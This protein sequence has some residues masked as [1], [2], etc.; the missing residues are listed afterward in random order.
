MLDKISSNAR[1]WNFF[2]ST[3][4]AIASSIWYPLI[5]GGGTAPVTFTIK[6]ISWLKF[7]DWIILYNFP[8]CLSSNYFLTEGD[9]VRPILHLVLRPEVPVGAEPP[10]Q[11][12][13][14]VL[15]RPR[16]L[17]QHPDIRHLVIVIKSIVHSPSRPW[18]RGK[19]YGP[20]KNFVITNTKYFLS[21]YSGK[22]GSE[23]TFLS[24]PTPV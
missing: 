17:R 14:H 16:L 9:T 21:I 15:R 5:S 22:L 18:Y 20:Y 10:Q 1:S 13:L 3:D 7:K 8:H 11:V 23:M 4:A 12:T 19:I 24:W 6:W 2:V